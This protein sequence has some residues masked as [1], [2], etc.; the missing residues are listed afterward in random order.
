MFKV[1][2]LK[3]LLNNKNILITGHTGFK[4][5]YLCFL[6]DFLGANV[7]GYSLK[8]EEGS[9]FDFLKLRK[10]LK[11]EK[12]DDIRN[13]DSLYQFINKINPDYIIHM[14]AQPLVL[15]SYKNPKWTYET[16]VN[17]TLNI[18][19]CIRV[20][21][22]QSDYKLKSF[23]NVTTDKVYENNDLEEYAFIENDKLCGYDPYANSKSCS[24][25]IT[26]SYKK[27]F[28][29]DKQFGVSTARAGNVIGAGDISKDR[30]IPDC[31]YSIKNN[32]DMII[33]NQYSIRPYQFVLEPIIVYLNILLKSSNNKNFEGCFNV[34]PD[35]SDCKT[36]GEIADMFFSNFDNINTKIIKNDLPNNNLHESKFLRLDNNLI[37]QK[38][39]YKSIC[40]I[41]T[42]INWTAKGYQL[43]LLNDL[44]QFEDYLTTTINKMFNMI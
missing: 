31:Y 19:E 3:Q 28:F 30:I 20:I 13:F 33:R 35:K 26:Y 41:K 8:E 43:I 1:E 39:G 42:A 16:N 25:L 14:A 15:E 17:G 11:D 9:L 10:K 27:S 24:E 38:F 7:Y 32:Q 29:Y 22:N 34:G 18:L 44:K 23:L 21:S 36:T 5:S 12:I 40:N 4:G 2:E 37:K 6:L